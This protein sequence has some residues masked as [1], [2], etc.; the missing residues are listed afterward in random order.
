MHSGPNKRS[1]NRLAT[2]PTRR[3]D[4]CCVSCRC[5]AEQPFVQRP[6]QVSGVVIGL[7][8]ADV[9]NLPRDSG[10]TRERQG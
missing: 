8:G 10:M 5:P 9:R 6:R 3:R 7:R 2:A 1:P 4:Q